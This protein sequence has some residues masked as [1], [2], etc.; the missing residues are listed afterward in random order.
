MTQHIKL[1]TI[2]NKNN[3]NKLV[4]ENDMYILIILIELMYIVF[5]PRYFYFSG[6]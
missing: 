6:P 3:K 4:F 1:N 2:K 5:V